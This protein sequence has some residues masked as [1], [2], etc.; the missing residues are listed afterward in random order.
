[1]TM[2]SS[3]K[4]SWR[5]LIYEWMLFNACHILYGNNHYLE[6]TEIDRVNINYTP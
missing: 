5:G 6:M 3:C 4:L 2:G 1:M